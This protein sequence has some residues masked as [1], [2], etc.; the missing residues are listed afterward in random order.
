M[1]RHTPEIR[2]TPCGMFVHPRRTERTRPMPE[3]QNYKNHTR[4]DPP[5]HFF[6]APALLLNV[7]FSIYLTIHHW[8]NHHFILL[9]WVFMSV[10]LL[11]AVFRARTHSL[12]AQD[13][14]IRLEERLRFA[15]L[16]PPEELGRSKTLTE[17]QIIGLRFASDEELPA[18]VKR[19]LDQGLT[20]KQ[21]K[22]SINNWRPDYLRI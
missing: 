6:I 20:Q 12:K 5:W 3:P 7:I 13:R 18:L 1:I 22:E 10:V 2:R 19:T 4:F 14:I 15:A 21:I 9:W 16:L 8:P 17:S 11:M